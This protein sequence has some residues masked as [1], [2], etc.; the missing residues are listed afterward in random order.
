[1]QCA[2]WYIGKPSNAVGEKRE[3]F[4]LYAMCRLANRNVQTGKQKKKP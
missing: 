2:N 4:E 1:M 3:N